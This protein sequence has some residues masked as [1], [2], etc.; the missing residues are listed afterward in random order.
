M[1]GLLD[2]LEKLKKIFD[3]KFLIT[4]DVKRE[5]VDK[6]ITIKRFELEALRIRKLIDDKVLEMPNS[7]EI[8]EN[9]LIKQIENIKNITNSTFVG[10]GREIHL[11]DSGEASCLALSLLLNEK[12]IKNVVAVD[13]RTTRLLCEN[14]ENLKKIMEHKLHTKIQSKKENYKYFNGIKIIRSVEL[15]YIAHKKGLIKIKDGKLVLDALLWALKLKGC[16]ISDTE[17]NEMKN[18]K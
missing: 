10:D 13:E 15:I 14:P 11:I 5:V 2:E 3:G 18:L 16:S 17:I 12:K 9:E 6:P 7:L 8:N 1:N 4:K